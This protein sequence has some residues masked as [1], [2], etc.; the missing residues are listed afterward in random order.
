MGDAGRGSGVD[1]IDMSGAEA[2]R[3]AQCE[4]YDQSGTLPPAEIHAE[5]DAAKEFPLPLGVYAICTTARVSTQA[6]NA[7]LLINQEHRQKGLFAVELFTWDR[8]DEL[9]EEF[10]TIRDQVY[11]TLS[12]EVAR[13]VQSG[14]SEIKL[15]LTD[16]GTQVV[17][18]TQEAA[19][20]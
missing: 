1:I 17:S 10:T 13:Q 8:L 4:F 14:L 19:D 2:L 16:L 7:I 20:G 12:G 3:A 11:G 18:T 15:Q 9:L 5:V 6:Q